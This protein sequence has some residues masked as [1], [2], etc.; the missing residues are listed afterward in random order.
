MENTILRITRKLAVLILISSCAIAWLL[1][2]LYL[3]LG[4]NLPEADTLRDVKLQTPMRVLS[5]DGLLIGQ[6]GEQKRSPL[7]F[8]EIPEHFVDAL[9]AAEDDQFFE[10]GGVDMLGLARAITEL[11]ATGQKRSGGSTLTMQ[12][13]RNYFLSLERTFLRKF[14]EILLAIEIE[15]ALSKEE[16]FELYVNRVFLGHR[17][18]GFEAAAQTYYGK[19]LSELNLAQQAMLAGIPKAPSRNNPL[20]NPEAGKNRRNWILGRME[21]LDLISAAERKSASAEPVTAAYHGLL[22]EVDADYVAEMV[23]QEMLTRFGNDAYNDGYVVHTTVDSKLQIAAKKSLIDGLKTYDSRH[24]W[25]GPEQR[26]P[27]L[28]GEQTE[29]LWLRWQAALDDMP[30][31]A[32]LTPAI[33][34]ATDVDGA[35][36]LDK[37]GL[38]HRLHWRGD[39]AQV[40]RFRTEN[41]TAAPSKSI[42][43]LLSTGDMIRILHDAES[44]QWRLTQV[45]RA[46]AALVSLNPKDG[47]IKALVGGMGFELSKFNRATQAR[48]QPGSNF[49]PFLYAAA[50]ESGITTATLI[51]DAP[52]V[53]DNLSTDQIWRPENDSGKFYGPTRLREALTF[54]RNLVSIRVLQRLGVGRFV[55]YVEQ[56]GFDTEGMARNLTLALGTHAFTPLEVASGY[57]I[58]ANGGY[59]VEPYLIERIE[60]SKGQVVFQADPVVAYAKPENSLSVDA[61]APL[62]MEDILIDDTPAHKQAAQVMDPRASFIVTSMLSDAIQRGTG[63]RA[64]VLKRDDISGKTGT[65]NGPRDAWFSGYNQELVTTAWVGFD[66]YSLLG[67]REFGGTAALPIWIGFMGEALSAD[68]PNVGM[69]EGIV[70]LRIDRASGRRVTGT[71]ENS[72]LEYFL[73]EFLPSESTDSQQP[74]GTDEL[75]GLF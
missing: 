54:S 75:E 9:L 52:V 16:I 68:A 70:R 5:Q 11:I 19:S 51:N 65:T 10:H 55:D 66:D 64:R 21:S 29:D 30:I 56:L 37:S 69:P 13:A 60:D 26:H 39:L 73:E 28:E 45:P 38:V 71:P 35:D 74:L 1:A 32:G 2:G 72:M 41:L 47:A 46:Q 23:R 53:L 33:V 4:P 25:R 31:I 48:R 43:E 36:V 42:E 18:Y 7:K 12:V 15:H 14:N 6:F 59:R 34:T 22:V 50:L 17:A 58:L 24:G 20:S 40:R 57:T 61:D 67:R 49:K 63:R 8:E 44:G 27:P 3:Y 62:R